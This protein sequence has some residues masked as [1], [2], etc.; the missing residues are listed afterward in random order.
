MKVAKG[1]F[2]SKVAFAEK[3][4]SALTGADALV[5]VTEWSEFRE[6]D[7]GRI[8]KLLRAPVVFDGR[9]IYNPETMRAHG[10]TYYSIGRR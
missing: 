1:I 2:G 7:F 5:I 4:Y 6:P 3:G 10:F 9:N 8:K